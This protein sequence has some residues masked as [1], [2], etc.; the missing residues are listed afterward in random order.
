[1]RLNIDLM[2]Y[3]CEQEAFKTI[4]KDW[5]R[6]GFKRE[7]K[8]IQQILDEDIFCLRDSATPH[9]ASASPI[10]QQ[11]LVLLRSPSQIY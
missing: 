11:D 9:R 3:L 5:I 2:N 8:S 6:F 10:Y 1:M 7:H 4:D